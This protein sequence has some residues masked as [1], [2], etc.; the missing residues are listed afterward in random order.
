MGSIIKHMDVDLL[1]AIEGLLA[2]GEIESGTPAF[3][4]ARQAA[5]QG[6][7]S[8]TASQQAIYDRIVLPALERWTTSS[9]LASDA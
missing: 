1:S 2:D 8:L 6:Y 7:A 9:G 3:A 5:H 4:V